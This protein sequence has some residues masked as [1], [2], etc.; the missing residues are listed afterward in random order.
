MKLKDYLEL[1]N[2]YYCLIFDGFGF[3][4]RV[5]EHFNINKTSRILNHKIINFWSVGM[6]GKIVQ[7]IKIECK[8]LNDIKD[9]LVRNIKKGN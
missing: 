2:G 9:F 7:C 4:S 1:S 5:F 8:N 6:E 3:R